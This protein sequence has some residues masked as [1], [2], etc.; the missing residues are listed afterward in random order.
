MS[1]RRPQLDGVSPE[2]HWPS[3]EQ[4]PS[5]LSELH[6]T[7]TQRPNWHCAGQRVQAWPANPQ[8]VAELPV[9]QI[10]RAS[11]QPEQLRELQRGV[12][13]TPASTHG[14]TKQYQGT[15]GIPVTGVPPSG[16]RGFPLP[17]PQ[18]QPL[19]SSAQISSRTE[20]RTAA[21]SLR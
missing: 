1:A 18:P 20:E 3:N 16:E 19:A 6:V 12:V 4:Q 9:W 17:P 2:R 5:Q 7:S 10:P 15:F 14:T 21:P 8:S 13:V 11:Q